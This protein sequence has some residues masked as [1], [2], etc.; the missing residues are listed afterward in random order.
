M[1]KLN[2]QIKQILNTPEADIDVEKGALILLKINRNQILYKNIVRKN[3]VKRLLYNLHKIYVTRTGVTAKPAP[4]KKVA[5][6][7]VV[8]GNPDNLKDA[9]VVDFEINEKKGKRGDH[10]Q[11]PDEIKAAYLENFNIYPQMRKLHE[12]LKLMNDQPE[13]E[14]KV[15][16]D[17]LTE[18]DK[19]H[20]ENWNIYDSYKINGTDEMTADPQK[21]SSARKYLSTNKKKV[22]TLKAK[23]KNVL[24]AK[25]QLRLDYLIEVNAGISDKQIDEYRKLGLDA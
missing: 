24:L 16:L 25:M 6:F 7:A 10:D 15:I 1:S 4:Q 20:R 11:L 2:E 21:I 23:E 18:L 19:K 9:K 3:D 22:A 12:Q 13:A 5:T 17:Q 8:Q 14:R